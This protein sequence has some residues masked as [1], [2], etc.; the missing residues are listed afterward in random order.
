MMFFSVTQ[1]KLIRMQE[2]H[3]IQKQK[4]GVSSYIIKTISI[5]VFIIGSVFIF[6]IVFALFDSFTLHLLLGKANA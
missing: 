5:L 4:A 2:K 3:L 1:D 6:G